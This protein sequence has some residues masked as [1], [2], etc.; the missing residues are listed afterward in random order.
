MLDLSDLMG[1]A[2]WSGCG[3][4]VHREAGWILMLMIVAELRAQTNPFHCGSLPPA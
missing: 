4:I 1:L 2:G 3:K